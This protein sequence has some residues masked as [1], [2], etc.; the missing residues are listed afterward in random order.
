MKKN[1]I[2]F[3][4][5]TI[6]IVMLV[7]CTT[8]LVAC[9]K[10][11]VDVFE[12][13]TRFNFDVARVSAFG[14]EATDMGGLVGLILPIVTDEDMENL[15][16]LDAK[17]SYVEFYADGTMH[18]QIQT[19][20]NIFNKIGDIVEG[21]SSLMGGGGEDVSEMNLNAMLADLHLENFI[22]TYI[23]PMFPGWTDKLK[24]GDLKGAM[25]L[26]ES[27]LGFNIT[28]IDTEDEGVK[29][30]V[31]SIA[32]NMRESNHF[33][34]DDDIDILGAFQALTDE[35]G[36]GVRI[37]I[38]FDSTYKIVSNV[39]SDGKVHQAI[40]LGGL[41]DNTSTQPWGV[42]TMTNNA[43]SD[44]ADLQALGG[45]RIV[46]RFNVANVSIPCNEVL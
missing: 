37:A 21:L 34:I 24:Q 40:Y 36:E 11:S 20:P 33:K 4:S 32:K 17:T 29:A 31:E 26:I 46:W 15:W 38:T 41:A 28:G 16:A 10:E 6:A 5:L 35:N 7:A 1:A 30:I 13:T 12:K 2:K 22:A 25:G 8:A 42:F 45:R 9:D 43:D 19:A 39:A 23:E 44:D 3:L 27:S 18:A 14:G